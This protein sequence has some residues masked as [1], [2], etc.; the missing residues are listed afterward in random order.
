MSARDPKIL[1]LRA[2]GVNCDRETAFAFERSGAKTETLHANRLIADKAPLDGADA[3]VVPGGFSYGDDLGAGKILGTKLALKLRTQVLRLVDRGGLVLGICNGFQV[4]VR[5]GLL[6]GTRGVFE[7]EAS[8]ARNLSGKFESRWVR[9][10]TTAQA[11]SPFLGKGEVWD[12]PSAHGEGRL[13][14]REA[15]VLE[16]MKAQGQIALV[17]RRPAE[18]EH[19]GV[20]GT[21]V[22]SGAAGYPWNPSGS[23][24]DIAGITDPTGRVLG[25]MPHPERHQDAWQR[26]GHAR[27]RS[28]RGTDGNAGGRS[29]P[30]DGAVRGAPGLEF[31]ARAVEALRTQGGARRR[32]G[33]LA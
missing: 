4:L 12:V 17:Y 28:V 9:L 22:A 5:A 13:V 30:R 2:P 25:L 18:G 32:E 6:P 16:R 21:G 19:P 29:A 7:Q 23:T 15:A 10:E 24:E 31:F 26:P 14:L 8:L 20:N 1:V 33:A 11:R 27:E 3:L